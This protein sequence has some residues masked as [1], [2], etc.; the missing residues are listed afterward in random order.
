MKGELLRNHKRALYKR[1]KKVCQWEVRVKSRA[2]LACLHSILREYIQ[3]DPKSLEPKR[4]L[5]SVSFFA[6]HLALG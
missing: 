3:Q 2:S 6:L 5:N 1:V 4:A